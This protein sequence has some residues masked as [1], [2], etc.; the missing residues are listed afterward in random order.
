MHDWSRCYGGAMALA[1]NP[2]HQFTDLRLG[3]HNLHPQRLSVRKVRCRLL[4]CLRQLLL[5]LCRRPPQPQHA[6]PKCSD[7]RRCVRT[8]RAAEVVTSPFPSC[9]RLSFRLC[10]VS[11]LL[12]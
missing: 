2:A 6:Q 12:H 7:L 10:S 4:V 3:F 9:P 5:Q 1:T 8:I 11:Q